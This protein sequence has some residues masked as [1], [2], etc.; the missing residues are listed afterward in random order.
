MP[1][2]YQAS[3]SELFS[4]DPEEVPQDENTRFNPVSPYGTAKLYALQICRNYRQ[5]YHMFICNGILFNHESKRRGDSFVTKKIINAVAKGKVVLGN[6]KASRD[7]GY[8]PEYVESMWLMLQQSKPDDYVIATG[9]TH[10]IEEFLNWVN[11]AT[12]KKMEVV[13]DFKYMRP[14]EVDVL[15]GNPSKAKEILGWEAKTRGKNLVKKML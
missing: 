1:K 4:G 2:I 13:T 15:R 3:T 5:A 11:E 10:T 9:E 12:G 14:N 7:W 8:A 6:L